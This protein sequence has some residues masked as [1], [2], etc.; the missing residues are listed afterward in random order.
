MSELRRELRLW[1]LVFLNIAAV[2]S[3]RWVGAAAHAG[4]GSITLW[5][6]AIVAFFLPAALVVASLSQRFPDEGGLYIWTKQAFGDWH[7]FLCAW[8]YFLSNLLFAPS[9]ALA[10]VAMSGFVWNTDPA[11][12]AQNR[13]YSL[14]VTLLL[15]WTAYLSH[16]FGLNIG[17]WAGNIGGA[18]TW[19][20]AAIL[21]AV[22]GWAVLHVGSVTKFHLLPE[23]NFDSLNIWSQ[24]AFAL[25]GLEL[26]P[27]LG[28]EIVNPRRNIP[29]AAWI[30]A[31]GS[32]LFYIGGTAAVLVL[33]EPA[34]VSQVT[35][36][37]QAGVAAG[38][39][40]RW[41]AFSQLFALLIVLGT[42]G[43]LASWIAGNTRLPFVIG[44]DRYLPPAFARLHPRWATPHVSILT[45]AIA[46]TVLLAA[47]QAGETVVA[48]YQILVDMTVLTTFLPYLY[49]FAAGWKF[50]QP[51]A[52]AF[53]L[54][55]SIAAIGLSIVPPPEVHSWPIF[56]AKVV[57]GCVALSG[58]GWVLFARYRPQSA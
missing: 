45:Q 36:I 40:L 23:A 16:L 21:V 56:E 46:A 10:G 54:L 27:I 50:G 32:A 52:A 24:I 19:G 13:V 7:A 37:V 31:A 47:T 28:G 11:Q 1:D 53:G 6:I 15:L 44:L 5:L 26:G 29:R 35:G 2:A 12:L 18:A 41:P 34:N 33:M 43:S 17:K 39:I 57:G 48:A 51:V 58:I 9:L 3:V 42:F 22:A 14:T 25:V 55:I 8:L 49:I 20:A 4:P 38:Q 30:S